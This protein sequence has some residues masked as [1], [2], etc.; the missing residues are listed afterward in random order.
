MYPTWIDT[1]LREV[2]ASAPQRALLL[3]PPGHPLAAALG[4]RVAALDLAADP[5][6]R[7]DL[8]IVAGTLESLPAVEARALLAHLRDRAAAHTVLWLD[9]SRAALGEE[10]V[11]AL[12]F[13]VLAR[14]GAQV[15]CG[16]DLADYKDRPDWL[17]AK[18]WA[19]PERWDRFRW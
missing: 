15:L 4:A 5:A 12:G 11:R 2:A 16:F 13:R 7:Y 19:N 6:R 18:H 9:A 10:D 3:A 14:D 17:N 8:A 1:L